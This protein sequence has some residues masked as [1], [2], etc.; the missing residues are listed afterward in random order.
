MAAILCPEN[1]QEEIP[2][3]MLLEKVLEKKKQGLRLVQICATYYNGG[4]ELSYSFSEDETYQLSTLR[5]VIDLEQMVPSISEIIPCAVFYENEMH[6]MFGVNVEMIGVDYHDRLYRI[7]TEMPFL[8]DDVREKKLE[9][10]G[11]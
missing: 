10:R 4:Y 6:E 3:E 9:E 1:V 8:P 7:K 5:V 2:I 11:Q